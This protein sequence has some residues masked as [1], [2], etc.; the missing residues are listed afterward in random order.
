MNRSKDYD[1]KGEHE[2]F[3]T[4][5]QR[6]RAPMPFTTNQSSSIGLIGLWTSRII[7]IE[8]ED[9]KAAVWLCISA[10]SRIFW[11][12]V[13]SVIMPPSRLEERRVIEQAVRKVFCVFVSRGVC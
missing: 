7:G 10:K 8:K 4:S 2:V 1:N 6:E 3:L 9:F 5:I 11:M 13:I 12:G